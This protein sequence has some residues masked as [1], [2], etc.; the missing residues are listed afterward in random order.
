MGDE[1]FVIL[2]ETTIMIVPKRNANRLY[3]IEVWI[4]GMEVLSEVKKEFDLQ[5]L[6]R[7]DN[8]KSYVV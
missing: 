2:N 1:T 6:S 5:K 7:P 4:E 3:Q 8:G